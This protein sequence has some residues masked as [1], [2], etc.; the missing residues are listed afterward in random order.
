MSGYVM[1]DPTAGTVNAISTGTAPT[2]PSYLSITSTQ[3]SAAPEMDPAYYIVSN[4]SL[5]V[6]PNFWTQ[7]GPYYIF[8]QIQQVKAGFQGAISAPFPFTNAAG[9]ASSYATDSQSL[10]IYSQAYENY[11]QAAQPLPSPFTIRDVNEVPQTFT[12]SDITNLYRGIVN[13]Q[14]SCNNALNNFVASIQAST[15]YSACTSIVWVTP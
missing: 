9:V 6:N 10:F 3:L 2:P 14:Q 4:G 7:R 5:V 12:V 8:R 11:I 1:Y 13:F 15:S